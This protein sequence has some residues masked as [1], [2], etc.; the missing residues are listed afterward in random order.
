[1]HLCDREHNFMEHDIARREI[2]YMD[3][4]LYLY[5]TAKEILRQAPQM[6]LPA[7]PDSVIDGSFGR[8]DTVYIINIQSKNGSISYSLLMDTVEA[9]L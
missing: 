5:L 7:C 2:T 6:V 9:D 3:R 4:S 8:C 1:M